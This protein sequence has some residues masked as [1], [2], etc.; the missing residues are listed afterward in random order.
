MY[1]NE[2]PWPSMQDDGSEK[3][4]ITKYAAENDETLPNTSSY[5]TFLW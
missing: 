2:K 3:A 1:K 4:K 5:A